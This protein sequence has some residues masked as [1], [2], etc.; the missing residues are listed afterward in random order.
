MNYLKHLLPS[1]KA[2][3]LASFI[4]ISLITLVAGIISLIP[5]RSLEEN[6]KKLRDNNIQA[7]LILNRMME[8]ESSIVTAERTLLIRQLYKAEE[9]QQLY[10]DMNEAEQKADIAAA[11]FDKMETSEEIRNAWFIFTESWT[12]LKQSRREFA[13]KMSELEV[14]ISQGLRAGRQFNRLADEAQSFAF[15]VVQ[16]K[17]DR[18]V[19][20]LRSLIE[21]INEGAV[22]AVSSSL[23]ST[24]V[25]TRWQV[26]MVVAA[27][28][29]AVLL[30]IWL[31]IR[32]TNPILKGV[33]YIAQV[34]NGNLRENVDASLLALDGETGLLARAIQQLIE[35]QRMEVAIA[36][37]MANGDYTSS[38]TLRSTKDELGMAVKGMLDVT[39]EALMK[40]DSAVSQ[41]TLGAGAINN[42]SQSLSQGAMETA[43]S[44]EE[45]SASISQIGQ[46]TRANASSADEADK[47]AAASR[48]A[49]DRGYDA[50][51]EMIAA[52]NDIH[53][54]G[55][56]IAKVVKLIDDIA[57]Q[58]NLLALNAAVEAARAGHHGRGFS[59]VAD[60]VKNLAGRSAKAAKET[61]VMVEQTV[62]K[63]EKG[64][65]LAE[66]TDKALR[67]VVSNAGRVADLFREIAKSSNEQSQGIGQIANGLS[68]IDRV[69]QHN[70]ITAGET[71]SAANALLRQAEGLRKMMEQFR[72]Y[73]DDPAKGK[74]M[75][76]RKRPTTQ[77]R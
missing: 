70:T 66:H 4:G 14:L 54:I 48:K 52:M 35:S 18:T 5:L 13:D 37:A 26:G 11:E 57:F 47:L 19:V 41:V 16:P 55:A 1:I 58:T 10:A 73:S 23:H 68:Q 29:L 49:A 17:R 7:I 60:E 28:I 59:I 8:A 53:D 77:V 15:E 31:S 3:L 9:R 36:R 40:V 63:I 21:I 22:Q 27:F 38:V 75:L 69:T 24:Q 42:A 71:A 46:K 56:Q 76:M 62:E 25:S 51:A 33:N 65:Q 43:S 44:L 34:A 12:D 67:E 39:K 45:I 6:I 64:A 74:E 20:E 61:A 72:L 50:V 30:S 2:K 32:I